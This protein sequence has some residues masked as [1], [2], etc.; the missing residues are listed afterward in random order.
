MIQ[1]KITLRRATSEIF[2]QLQ[3][4]C[5]RGRSN[6]QLCSKEWSNR[7]ADPN[8]LSV[9]QKKASANVNPSILDEGRGMHPSHLKPHTLWWL[10]KAP[11]GSQ[12]MYR[13]KYELMNQVQPSHYHRSAGICT[14]RKNLGVLG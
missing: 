8:L 11:R 13:T 4:S 9:S 1:V 3:W 7:A 10:C 12:H 6:A 2:I 14:V 5:P